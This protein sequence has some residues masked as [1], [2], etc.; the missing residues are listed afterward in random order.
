MLETVVAGPLRFS[1]D[2]RFLA[3]AAESGDDRIAIVDVAS[4]KRWRLFSAHEGGV[5]DLAYPA[6]G[7]LL[8]SAGRDG[9]LLF[10][11]AGR[12]PV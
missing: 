2:G 4:G 3:C 12:V 10:W 7:R 6:D 9:T 11:D 8:A 5:C 1:P